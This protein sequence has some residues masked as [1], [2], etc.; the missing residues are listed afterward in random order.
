MSNMI[1]LCALPVVLGALAIGLKSARL[2]WYVLLAG[3]AV[4]VVVVLALLAGGLERQMR[5]LF[6]VEEL[7]LVVMLAGAI[8]FAAVV[9]HIGTHRAGSR[10]EPLFTACLLWFLASMNLVAIARHL[11]LLW[12]AIEATTLATAPLIYHHRSRRSLEAVWKYL[13]LC[14]VGIERSC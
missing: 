8:V 2:R 12:V 1:L 6:G 7:G 9:T 5:P 13:L 11:A 14:S 3:A 4:N 10:P